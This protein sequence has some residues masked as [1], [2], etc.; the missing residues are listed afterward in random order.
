ML[1]LHMVSSQYCP[2]ISVMK[3]GDRRQAAAAV[4]TFPLRCSLDYQSRYQ[5]YY[6]QIYH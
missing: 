4:A 3:M 2:F 5:V 6:S 1:R